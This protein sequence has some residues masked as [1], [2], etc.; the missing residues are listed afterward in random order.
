VNKQKIFK[1]KQLVEVCL[2]T[3]N[4]AKL[5]ATTLMLLRNMVIS[6]AHAFQIPIRSDAYIH[7]M[8]FQVNRVLSLKSNISP[9]KESMI[10]RVKLIENLMKRGKGHI[11]L[12]YIK[13]AIGLYF[14]LQQVSLPSSELTINTSSR[15]SSRRF[16]LGFNKSGNESPI[17][18]L[19]AHEL[20]SRE[21]SLRSRLDVG[22]DENAFM[23]LQRMSHL[24]AFLTN[25]ANK[26]D[27]LNGPVSMDQRYL[28]FLAQSKAIPLLGIFFL[29]TTLS[30]LV[31][32]QITLNFDLMAPLGTFFLMFCGGAALNLYLYSL[33]KRKAV[34]FS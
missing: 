24:R 7:N 28:L 31:L 11:P 33:A 27:Q 9:Y 2:S 25:N 8:M 13:D 3:K 10:T 19:I 14:D 6:Q 17:Q 34:N 5:A 22:G 15:T 12:R 16:F 29:L 30:L 20:S 18:D 21:K 1:F 4:Y 32:I 26:K 23:E